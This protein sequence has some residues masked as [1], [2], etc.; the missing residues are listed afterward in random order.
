MCVVARFAYCPHAVNLDTVP[1]T[2]VFGLRARRLRNT[3]LFGTGKAVVPNSPSVAAAKRTAASVVAA[4]HAAG[5][6]DAH[7]DAFEV[8]RSVWHAECGHAVDLRALAATY[9]TQATPSRRGVS[10][11][12][13]DTCIRVSAN[14]HCTMN[15]DDASTAQAQWRA[16]VTDVLSRFA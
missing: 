5:V 12:V 10:F 11:A 4:L 3:L 13:G 7:V 1:G 9:P 14:G 6:A 16:F 15:V 8:C 2:R